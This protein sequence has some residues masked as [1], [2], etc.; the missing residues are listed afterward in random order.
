M[1]LWKHFVSIKKA[2]S[3]MRQ[4]HVKF[5]DCVSP[6]VEQCLTLR[7]I[8][9]FGLLNHSPRL[10]YMETN[11]EG[12]IDLNVSFQNHFSIIFLGPHVHAYLDLTNRAVRYLL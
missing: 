5:V 9:F 7:W 10:Q 6:T 11:K 4:K 2:Q 3:N 8:S 1:A 12:S